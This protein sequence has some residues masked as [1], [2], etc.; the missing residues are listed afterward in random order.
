MMSSAEDLKEWV[1][2]VYHDNVSAKQLG[3]CRSLKPSLQGVVRCDNPEPGNVELCRSVDYFPAFCH[4][5]S[6]A[7][8]YGLHQ[9]R[10][11]FAQLRASSHPTRKDMQ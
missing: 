5:P 4:V 2:V 1:L 9:T 10:D 8:V 3:V 7:C 6:N 11:E